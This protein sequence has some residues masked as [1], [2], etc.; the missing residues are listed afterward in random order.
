MHQ[1]VLA[2]PD[3]VRALRMM[4]ELYDQHPSVC[5]CGDREKCVFARGLRYDIEELERIIG[6]K[7]L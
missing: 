5:K 4:R 3:K 7:T 6:I 1:Q 2:M